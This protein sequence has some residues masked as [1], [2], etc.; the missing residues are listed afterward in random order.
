MRRASGGVLLLSALLA[1]GGDGGS[2]PEEPF[3]DAAGLYA[4]EGGFDGLTPEEASFV[5]T[6]DLGQP[7]RTDDDLTGTISLTAQVDGQVIGFNDQPFSSASVTSTGVLTLVLGDASA[8]WTLTGTLAGDE[9]NGRHTLTDGVEDFSGDW[10]GQRT[11]VS[12]LGPAAGSRGTPAGIIARLR[13]RGA[14]IAR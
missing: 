13:G 11:S 5:G 12:I 6:L 10:S 9:I 8:S 3:P 2:D 14:A 1:C 7:S 4:I